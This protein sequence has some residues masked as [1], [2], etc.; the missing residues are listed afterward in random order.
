[1]SPRGLT[2]PYSHI[3]LTKSLK[4]DLSLWL[5][6]LNSFNGQSYWQSEFVEAEALGLLTDAAGS[7]GFGPGIGVPACG[8]PHGCPRI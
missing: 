8:T 5:E 6:F 2:S 4:D 1:M 7:I 3:K